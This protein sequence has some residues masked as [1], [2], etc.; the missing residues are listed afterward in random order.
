M[1]GCA[2]PVSTLYCGTLQS[3]SQLHSQRLMGLLQ[4]RDRPHLASC[5]SQTV[6][7]IILTMTGHKQIRFQQDE[8]QKKGI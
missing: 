6:K 8:A 3:G 2:F 4:E 5:G 1:R 7:R